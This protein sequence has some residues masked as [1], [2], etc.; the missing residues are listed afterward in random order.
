MSRDL[1]FAAVVGG[2]ALVLWYV[3]RGRGKAS[4]VA[5]NLVAGFAAGAREGRPRPGDAVIS[6]VPDFA[7]GTAMY[8]EQSY[9][10]DDL[11]TKSVV[12]KRYATFES[13]PTWTGRELEFA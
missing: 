4:G 11:A 12:D 8:G 1:K 5:A 9:K 10:G 7:G 3:T 6:D 13:P 2:A